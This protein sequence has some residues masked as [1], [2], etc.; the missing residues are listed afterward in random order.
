M[1]K[2]EKLCKFQKFDKFCSGFCKLIWS[3]II[4]SYFIGR[5]GPPPPL[6]GDWICICIFE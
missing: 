5:I 1:N 4:L 3:N 2:G 6:H